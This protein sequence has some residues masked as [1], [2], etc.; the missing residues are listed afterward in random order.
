MNF[1]S[2]STHASKSFCRKSDKQKQLS[3]EQLELRQLLAT[4]TW[5]TGDIT[6]ISNVSTNGNSV[7]AINGSNQ[8]GS[9]TTANGVEFVSSTRASAESQSQ[10]QSGANESLT[11]TINN[12][13]G[14]SFTNGGISGAMGTLI[15]GGWWGD[16]S[17]NLATINLAG[18]SVGDEY[19]LQIFSSDARAG[20]NNDYV[21]SVGD[22]AG[23]TG[24]DLELNNQPF[25]DRAGDFGIGTFTADSTSQTIE[26]S[27]FI[28]GSASGGRIHV[29]AIQLRKL[30]T[31]VLMQGEHPLINEFSAS[32]SNVI[33]DDNGNSS[34]WI[35]IFNAGEDA[36]DL[37]G[38]SLTDDSA[39]TTK[40]VF[41]DTTLQGGQYLVVF[42]G[43]DTDTTT[44]T[45]LYTGFALSA[46]GEYLG[47]YDDTGALVTEFA[48][49]GGD[50][51]QQYTD[52]SFGFVADDSYSVRSYFATPT[53]GS[54]N[55]NPVEGV[56]E[57]VSASVTPG[58]YDSPQTVSLSTPTSGATIRYTLD[59]STPTATHGSIYT[60]PINITGTTTLRSVATKSGFQ[61]VPD[62]TFSYIFVDDVLTQS[63]NGD[64]PAG[65]PEV[66]S[67]EQELDYG[68]DP[69]VIGIEGAQAVKDALLAIPSWSITTDIDNL[70][71]P[72][73]G[74]Y[75][76]PEEDGNAWE[77]AASVE[78]LNPDGS[79]GFQVNAGLRIRGASSRSPNNPKHSFKL[80]FRGQYGDSTLDYDVFKDTP[81][82]AT[83]F[84]RID[85]RT[86]QNYSWSKDGDEDNI[87]ITDVFSRQ[88]QQAL[89]QPSTNSSWIHLYLNG[90]YWGLYQTQE[91]VDSDFA[92][93]YFGGD[94][95]NYDVIK[96]DADGYVNVAADG[97]TDAYY[98]LHAQALARAA[99]GVT[100]AFA[101]NAAYMEAQGLNPDGSD[102]PAI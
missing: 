45:D 12:N 68:I 93:S 64:A 66:G 100:P 10:A 63:N 4:I 9:T 25:G 28:D 31:V 81:G 96:A 46:G 95:E 89:G 50:Y 79:P 101:D 87:F 60:G 102:N 56:V 40:F 51:A 48:V 26:L 78:Q 21:M 65:F 82:T 41:P 94:A 71:D 6:G 3:Y 90:Q 55:F 22:G 74:I 27:G 75:S 59:G 92:E 34:D 85:I 33:D 72:T 80:F 17:N 36:A 23:G 38:Y 83:S 16:S 18:L 37:T 30:G 35:E 7:F 44:G 58:F 14:S 57:R 8:T 11:T 43:D 32:N 61:T 76:N 62:R 20:R 49:G 70:F 67:L 15:T 39:N 2:S 53:P 54:R 73:T 84:E 52:V 99:D 69:E 29:N 24:T 98:A 1:Q 13:N 77:R 42:A 88:N 5:T 47:F 97:N 91:R 86:A 19:E